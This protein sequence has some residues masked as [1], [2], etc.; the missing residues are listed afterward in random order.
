MDSDCGSPGS[1][2]AGAADLA[3]LR[4]GVG[5]S[6]NYAE[7]L[8]PSPS[9]HGPEREPGAELEPRS[10][11]P[12]GKHRR[13]QTQRVRD[14]LSSIDGLVMESA[15]PEEAFF[16]LPPLSPEV[17]STSNRYE[18]AS[19]ASAGG[20]GVGGGGGSGS[21]AR[22]SRSGRSHS[23]SNSNSLGYSVR[24][25]RQSTGGMM[26]RAGSG[27]SGGAGA[28]G[29]SGSSSRMSLRTPPP[30]DHVDDEADG[31]GGEGGEGGAQRAFFPSER[32]WRSR[33]YS[34]TPTSEL[35]SRLSSAPPAGGVGKLEGRQ[36]G[37]EEEDAGMLLAEVDWLIAGTNAALGAGPVG[38][39]GP[40]ATP[41]KRETSTKNGSSVAGG[42]EEA[43]EA[44]EEGAGKSGEREEKA[45]REE[46]GDEGGNGGRDGEVEA[47]TLNGSGTSGGGGKGGSEERPGRE[48]DV[49]LAVG[50]AD[51]ALEAVPLQSSSSLAEVSLDTA[52][53]VLVSAAAAAATPAKVATEAAARVVVV[54]AGGGDEQAT[55][56][57]TLPATSSREERAATPRD[58]PRIE[59][60]V[61]NGD[62]EEGEGKREGESSAVDAV[63][64]SVVEGGV[65]PKTGEAG[66]NGVA[67]LM[68]GEGDSHVGSSAV[69]SLAESS[70]S[71]SRGVENKG[72]R[73]GEIVAVDERNGAA[74]AL[75]QGGEGNDGERGGMIVDVDE[76]N[77]AAVALPPNGGGFGV[78]A[79]GKGVSG[80]VEATGASSSSGL[81]FRKTVLPSPLSATD[82]SPVVFDGATGR[83]I[84]AGSGR[85]GGDVATAVHS[86]D[87]EQAGQPTLDD[88][89]L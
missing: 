17:G 47:V 16:H 52:S 23:Q 72:G 75:P 29:P 63:V 73:R 34:G 87:G 86:T 85:D 50:K 66:S 11:S 70:T 41:D 38:E 77:V 15:R 89:E 82:I 58:V 81:Q 19:A 9:S 80:S 24:G 67:F 49:G 31:Y 25:K 60:A 7:G 30:S 35:T 68:K 62:A 13:S 42:A 84:N 32:D 22:S 26:Y 56:A 48:G 27:G 40:A 69:G 5:G 12:E 78:L 6:A 65:R 18:T 71:R 28:G 79:G 44:E 10:P 37:E 53:P 46:T 76:L 2:V 55:S 59:D 57:T 33:P 64:E 51:T 3:G 1:S 43:G 20:G 14:L 83:G 45:R 4:L 21:D 74:V 8:H 39:S 88:V 36:E 54:A 61:V